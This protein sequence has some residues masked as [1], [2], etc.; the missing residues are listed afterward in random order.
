MQRIDKI[1]K[2]V[3]GVIED[4][5][6]TVENNVKHFLK[7]PIFYLSTGE[8]IIFEGTIYKNNLLVYSSIHSYSWQHCSLEYSEIFKEL[9]KEIS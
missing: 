9:K 6:P 8:N 7:M 5:Y 1:C 4:F 2:K 3:F